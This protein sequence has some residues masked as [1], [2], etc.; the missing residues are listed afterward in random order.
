MR[1]YRQEDVEVA[2]RPAAKAGLAL[3]GQP[4][5]GAVLDA[6]RNVDRQRPLLGDAAMAGAFGA[7]VLDRLAAA[8]ALRTG[9]FDRKEALRGA[10]PAGAGAQRAGRRLGSGPGAGAAAIA[11][12]DGGRHTDLRGLAGIG[13]LERDLHIVAQV[14]AALASAARTAAPAAHHLTE[15]ILENVG[16]AAAAKAVGKTAATA[17]VVFESGMS[18]PVI[19]R[20]LLRVL[21]RLVG[22]VDFLELLLARRVAGIAIGMELH[23][24]LAESAL[25][26]LLVGRFADTQRFVEISFH[27]VPLPSNY[28]GKNI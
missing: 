12:G 16:K 6:R 11:A 3:I 18:E 21:Q 13:F 19:S 10:H 9:A 1:P 2:G 28:S 23:G 14:G 7:G 8:M 5:A 4:Y 20:A 26:S 15:N 17:A 24:E 25:E 27:I 22:F